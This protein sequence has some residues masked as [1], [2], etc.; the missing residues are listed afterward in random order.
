MHEPYEFAEISLQLNK[1]R[2]ISAYLQIGE[3]E[4]VECVSVEIVVCGLLGEEY[5]TILTKFSYWSSLMKK[6]HTDT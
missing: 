3:G 4:A 6:T 2:Q 1:F 5:L